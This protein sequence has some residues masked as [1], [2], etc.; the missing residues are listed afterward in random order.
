MQTM[1][2]EKTT[3]D[4]FADH[5]A[6]RVLE[7]YKQQGQWQKIFCA[8]VPMLTA[9]QA[10]AILGCSK[11]HLKTLEKEAHLQKQDT[12]SNEKYKTVQVLQCLA[13]GRTGH[14]GGVVIAIT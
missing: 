1:I 13:E 2:L 3:V 10:S 14:K 9:N 11:D 5:L 8:L 6:N 12:N 4:E 7:V